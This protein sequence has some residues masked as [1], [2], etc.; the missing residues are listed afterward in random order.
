M[1]ADRGEPIPEGA[2]LDANGNPTTDGRAAAVWLPF[3][4][5]KGAGLALLMDALAGAFTGAACA[6]RK[7][8]SGLH[9]FRQQVRGSRR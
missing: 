7:F 1:A 8:S 5:A 4:G 9:M 6:Q 2:A 3:G